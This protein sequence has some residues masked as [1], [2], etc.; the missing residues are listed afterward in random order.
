MDRTKVFTYSLLLSSLPT[1]LA[2]GKKT[3]MERG[4][5]QERPAFP[6][7]NCC[8]FLPRGEGGGRYQGFVGVVVDLLMKWL[9]LMKV[10]ERKENLVLGKSEGEG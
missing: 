1:W 9:V 4:R 10:R 7:S 6:C 2:C 8:L 5:L 3:N